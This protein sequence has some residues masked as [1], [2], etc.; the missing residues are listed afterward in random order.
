ML[1]YLGI[2]PILAVIFSAIGLRGLQLLSVHGLEREAEQLILS[3]WLGLVTVTLCLMATALILPLSPMTGGLLTLLLWGFSISQA[4]RHKMSQLFAH[5]SPLLLFLLTA[6][7]IAIAAWV[8]REVTSVDA[9]LYHLGAIKWLE[10]YGTVPGIGLINHRFGFTSA[11]FAI[12]A[13]FVGVSDRLSVTLNGFILWVAVVHGVL[14]AKQIVQRQAILADWFVVAMSGLVLPLILRSDIVNRLI[15][16]SPDIPVLLLGILVPWVMLLRLNPPD[17]FMLQPGHERLLLILASGAVAIR[18]SA[19]PLLAIACLFVLTRH[20]RHPL[21]W[22]GD[23]L[24]VIAIQI[25]SAIFGVMT[26][27][28]AF[29]PSTRLCLET[30][31][32]IKLAEVSEAAAYTRG[33]NRWFG[34]PP[35]GENEWLWSFMQWFE[36]S[37]QNRVMACLFGLSVL[38]LMILCWL[39]RSLWVR[40]M[41]WVMILGGL[42]SLFVMTQGP[43]LRFGLSYLCTLPA[44]L[45]ATVAYNFISPEPR[46]TTLEWPPVFC[47]KPLPWLRRYLGIL[48]LAIASLMSAFMVQGNPWRLWLPPPVPQAVVKSGQVNDVAYVYTEAPEN[49]DDDFGQCW[50]APLPCAAEPIWREIQ[51]HQPQQGYRGG[52]EVME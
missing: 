2:W 21:Q 4:V 9:G 19:L 11:W 17:A 49:S 29:F 33:W 37:T 42:G 14:C 12:T 36:S 40:G 46:L 7:A 52:F 27:G 32:A 51:L 8:S 6:M 22:L 39:R 34:D 26:S 44:L 15:S 25:P 3:I 10:A 18:L 45:A 43:I 41:G 20:Y 31:W 5:R 48:S 23:S 28:C 24:L 13:P 50:A 1:Y 38:S 30:P 47:L 16:P 35:A